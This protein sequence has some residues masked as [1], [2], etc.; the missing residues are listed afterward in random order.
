MNFMDKTAKLVTNIGGIKPA[1]EKN[2]AFGCAKIV[3]FVA[4]NGTALTVDSRKLYKCS[5]W[6]Y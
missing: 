4:R 1:F 2:L 6:L 5:L 3:I